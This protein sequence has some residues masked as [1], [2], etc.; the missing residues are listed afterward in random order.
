MPT[1]QDDS[2]G[3]ANIVTDDTIGHL[4]EKK[5][6]KLTCVKFW[7]VAETQLFKYTNK[8][9]VNPHQFCSAYLKEEVAGL[10]PNP[11][12]MDFRI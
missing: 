3:N 6:F 1:I 5:T 8:N 10:P 4:T 12:H 11:V 2:E 7:T 9:T